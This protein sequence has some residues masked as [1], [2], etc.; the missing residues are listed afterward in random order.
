MA[1]QWNK[2]N[3]HDRSSMIFSE[4]TNRHAEIS[5]RCQ[6]LSEEGSSSSAWF[7]RL[8]FLQFKEARIIIIQRSSTQERHPCH[9]T[10]NMKE[11]MQAR[12]ISELI[13]VKE[14][15]LIYT[16]YFKVQTVK[17]WHKNTIKYIFSRKASNPTNSEGK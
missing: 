7:I 3:T 17:M 4:T 2:H 10:A 12:K 9:A 15:W 14:V 5:L 1:S 8:V 16:F 13:H 6:P 11:S